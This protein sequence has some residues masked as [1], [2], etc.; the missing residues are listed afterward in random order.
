[1]Y[2]CLLIIK[3]FQARN[4]VAQSDMEPP[5]IFFIVPVVNHQNVFRVHTPSVVSNLKGYH[6][7]FIST[8][9]HNMYHTATDQRMA[10]D[11]FYKVVKQKRRDPDKI[12]LRVKFI[13][14]CKGI[15]VLDAGNLNIMPDKIKFLCK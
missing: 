10:D 3:K 8:E 11:I 2:G 12:D 6:F 5:G 7:I 15:R 4:G 9:K 13:L 14:E 1:M